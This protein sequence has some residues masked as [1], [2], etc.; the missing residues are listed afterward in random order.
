VANVLSDSLHYDHVLKRKLFL[1]ISEPILK[2]RWQGYL[3]LILESFGN[4]VNG[5]SRLSK[6]PFPSFWILSAA[7]FAGAILAFNK[8]SILGIGFY[9][10]HMA[11]LV[12]VCLFDVPQPRFVFATEMLVLISILVIGCGLLLRLGR[13]SATALQK[14]A[15]SYRD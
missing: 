15:R 10:G 7:I 9:L 1:E 5:I 2:K 14:F 8:Y 13:L 11:H 6:S 12:V 3:A 4:A